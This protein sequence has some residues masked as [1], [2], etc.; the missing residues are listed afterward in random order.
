[1]NQFLTDLGSKWE[2]A[3]AARD[4]AIEVPRLDSAVA[5]EVL[6]LAR[7]AAHTGERQFAPLACYLAGIAAER[8]RSARPGIT[9]TELAAYISEVR[10]SLESPAGPR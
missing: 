8:L 10:S 6:D 4:A 2:R 5:S 9:D 3:A 7:V 1:M